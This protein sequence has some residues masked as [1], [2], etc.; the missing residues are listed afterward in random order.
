MTKEYNSSNIRGAGAW[1]AEYHVWLALENYKNEFIKEALRQVQLKFPAHIISFH[2]IPAGVP[3]AWVKDDTWWQQRCVLEQVDRPLMEIDESYFTNE[4][5]KKN[6]REKINRLKR[7]GELSFVRITDDAQFSE[8]LDELTTQFDL[9]KGAMFNKCPFKDSPLSKELL[10]VYFKKGLLHATV[11][12]LNSLV[13]ASN[14][15]FMSG[16]WLHLQGLNSHSASHAKF[17]PGILAFLMLGKMLAEEGYDVFDL[18]PG[19]DT[20]K[21]GLANKY[22]QAYNLTV[23]GYG[24]RAKHELKSFFL[25]PLKACLRQRGY[26]PLEIRFGW[27]KFRERL[28]IA[29]TAGPAGYL[30]GLSKLLLKSEGTF[31]L[32]KISAS[33]VVVKVNCLDDLLWF[34]QQGGLL[35]RWDFLSDCEERLEAGQQPLTLRTGSLL[36][37]CA[38]LVPASLQINGLYCH[39]QA[40]S[41]LA[42]FLAGVTQHTGTDAVLLLRDRELLAVLK[43][44]GVRPD[45]LDLAYQS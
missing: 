36:L 8:V 3:V 15:S 25:K 22:D 41:S 32:A 9:R 17:S 44:M 10:K 26:N 14:V 18:T 45:K 42:N 28:R 29:Y 38:W 21:D 20:Y 31:A 11:L 43:K 24:F 40:F 37:C 5:K 34:D 7:I 16:S 23:G 19:G 39:K 13:I 33:A 4:L 30:S 35:T 1:D 27:Y 12:K 6:R 2:Y